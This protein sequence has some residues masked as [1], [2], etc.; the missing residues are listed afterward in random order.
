MWRKADGRLI[1]ILFFVE[2]LSQNFG[3][4][5]TILA[6]LGVLAERAT[7]SSLS[8]EAFTAYTNS[9]TGLLVIVFIGAQAVGRLAVTVFSWHPLVRQFSH[10]AMP[11]LGSASCGAILALSPPG[12]V[13]ST[14]VPALLMLCVLQGL[15]FATSWTIYPVLVLEKFPVRRVLYPLTFTLALTGPMIATV[16]LSIAQSF[17]STGY[18]F[19]LFT[20]LYVVSL[21]LGLVLVPRL[22]D[23]QS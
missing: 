7:P 17:L 18:T 16:V 9:L 22:K 19:T 21:A 23:K 2:S 3:V 15:V 4:S 6:M 10:V 13:D 11:V 12:G 5:A 8:T 20:A 1:A 14:T